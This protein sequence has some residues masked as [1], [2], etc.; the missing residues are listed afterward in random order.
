MRMSTFNRSSVH[1]FDS[2]NASRRYGGL[3]L[4]ADSGWY[5]QANRAHAQEHS[6][7]AAE[8]ALEVTAV[9][10]GNP[11]YTVRSRTCIAIH[12]I[13]MVCIESALESESVSSLHSSL[14]LFQVCIQFCIHVCIQV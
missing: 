12:C 9:L 13:F 4:D 11:A 1:Q 2:Y 5:P 3:H 14:S 7:L 8:F 6:E 10:S